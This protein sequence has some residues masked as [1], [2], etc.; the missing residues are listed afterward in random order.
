MPSYPVKVW[1]G[2]QW[3]DVAAQPADLSDYALQES[4][5]DIIDPYFLMGA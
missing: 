5:D 4:V 3:V 2:S 1:D